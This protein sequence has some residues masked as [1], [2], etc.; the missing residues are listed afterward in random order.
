M[1]FILVT[2]IESL[3][4]TAILLMIG[5]LIWFV[6]RSRRSKKQGYK[7]IEDRQELLYDMVAGYLLAVPVLSFATFAILIMIHS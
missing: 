6:M 4:L 3:I 5:Y 1:G 7:M 2:Y